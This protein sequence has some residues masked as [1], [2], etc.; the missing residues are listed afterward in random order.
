MQKFDFLESE[1]DEIKSKIRFT[2]RQIR[3]IDYRRDRLTLEEMAD[4]EHCDKST[5]SREIAIIVI[6]IMRVI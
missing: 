2:P 3:I 4:L 1:L 5:I 6:K